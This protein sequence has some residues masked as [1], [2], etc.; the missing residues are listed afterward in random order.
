MAGAVRMKRAI[1]PWMTSLP[2]SWPWVP[3]LPPVAS[4]DTSR[5]VLAHAAAQIGIPA[6]AARLQISER[7]LHHYLT[8]HSLIPDEVFLRA[9]DV[10]I[11]QPPAPKPPASAQLAVNPNPESDP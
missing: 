5:R 8:G 10:I 3:Y 6:L 7:I 11:E 9:V 4:H 1:M 2:Q